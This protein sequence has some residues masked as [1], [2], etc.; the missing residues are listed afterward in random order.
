M[1]GFSLWHWMIIG[2]LLTWAFAVGRIL[3]RLG[4]HP[5]WAI[6]SVVPLFNFLGIW[7][8]ALAKWPLEERAARYG[9][10]FE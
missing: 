1:G 8:V 10:P 5:A 4:F 2:L 7:F 6:L 9:E 3:K